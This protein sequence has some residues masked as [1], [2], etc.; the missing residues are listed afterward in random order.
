GGQRFAGDPAAMDRLAGRQAVGVLLEAFDA[1][2]LAADGRF[3]VTDGVRPGMPGKACGK[4]AEQAQHSGVNARQAAPDAAGRGR[5]TWH[6]LSYRSPFRGLTP[7]RGRQA[8]LVTG[9][10]YGRLWIWALRAAGGSR[11]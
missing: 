9:A 5:R 6:S 11:E 3:V 4:G 2:Q 1:E 8:W 7:K 10:A